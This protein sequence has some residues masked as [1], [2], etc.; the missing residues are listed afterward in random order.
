MNARIRPSSPQNNGNVSLFHS[1]RPLKKDGESSTNL[2]ANARRNRLAST[3]R[4][5]SVDKNRFN[6]EDEPGPPSNIGKQLRKKRLQ[7]Q[8]LENSLLKGRIQQGN[9]N[10]RTFTC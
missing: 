8:K 1:A 3:L 6:Q 5:R 2:A 4:A 9:T 7:Q 10:E